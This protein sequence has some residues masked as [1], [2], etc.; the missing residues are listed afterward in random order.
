MSNLSITAQDISDVVQD[1]LDVMC[2]DCF[3]TALDKRSLAA[4]ILRVVAK[5]STFAETKVGVTEE[6][7]LVSEIIKIAAELDNF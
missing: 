7:V 1:I 4:D 6:V 3:E 5:Q 2:F